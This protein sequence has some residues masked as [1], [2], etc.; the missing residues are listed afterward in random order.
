MPIETVQMTAPML[1]NLI[2]ELKKA[3]VVKRQQPMMVMARPTD[4]GITPT[5]NAV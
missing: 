2:P 3:S 4:K 5:K 1:M